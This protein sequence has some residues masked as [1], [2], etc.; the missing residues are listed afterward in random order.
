MKTSNAATAPFPPASGSGS[1]PRLAVAAVLGAALLAAVLPLASPATAQAPGGTASLGGVVI[2]AASGV[3]I[4]GATVRVAG[5][6][7]TAVTDREGRFLMYELVPGRRMLEVSYLGQPTRPRA[8][9]LI[10]D[11]HAEIELAVDLTEFT[12]AGTERS[13]LPDRD[14]VIPLEDLDVEVEGTIAIGKLHGFHSRM[15]NGD[16]VF[17]TREDILDRDPSRP[18]DLLRGVPGIRINPSTFERQSVIPSRGQQG[19]F[20]RCD[21]LYFLDGLE[22]PGFDV[23]DIPARDLA[24]IEIYRSLSEIPP[25]FRRRGICAAILLWTR[26]PS[27]PDPGLGS[28]G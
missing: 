18:S 14:T 19:Q 7:E 21:L 12:V 8:V 26:D 4:S 11:R 20:Q 17:I 13:D 24:G 2:E 22:V 28:R 27:V 3:P 9:E 16:G 6:P 1:A 5:A 23:D 25:Q 10:E 15:E